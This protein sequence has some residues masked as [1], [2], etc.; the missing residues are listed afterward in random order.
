MKYKIAIC[1]CILLNRIYSL[2][3]R[4]KLSFLLSD[5]L[6]KYVQVDLPSDRR[7]EGAIKEVELNQFVET[8]GM[9]PNEPIE[10]DDEGMQINDSNQVILSEVDGV[11]V[12]FICL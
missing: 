8:G 1:Y 12:R 9:Q 3:C 4:C 10:T 11:K 7:Y 2:L 5:L 6:N